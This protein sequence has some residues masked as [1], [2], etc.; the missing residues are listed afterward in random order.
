MREAL[1]TARVEAEPGS[2]GA[3]PWFDATPGD[4]LQPRSTHGTRMVE[5]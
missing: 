4:R 1:V 5:T 2:L 3:Q